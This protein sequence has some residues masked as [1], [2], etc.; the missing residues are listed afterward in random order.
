M[1]RDAL[2]SACKAYGL[3]IARDGTVKDMMFSY[4]QF[5]PEFV[6]NTKSGEPYDF[7]YSDIMKMR[8]EAENKALVLTLID[9][10]EVVLK[11]GA[12]YDDD[13][14]I[15]IN[16]TKM[17]REQS[18]LDDLFDV[19]FPDFKEKAY[20]DVL[21]EQGMIDPT[22]FGLDM[23]LDAT[24][25]FVPLVDEMYPFYYDLME[26][27]LRGM[28]L[29]G[30]CPPTTMRDIVLKKKLLENK[31][32]LFMEWVE[33][34]PWDGKPRLRRWFMDG[35]GATSNG[36]LTPEE[37]ELYIG[38]FTT[39]WF[40]GG[41]CR[42]REETKVE[43]VPVIIGGEGLGKG[44]FLRYTVGNNSEWFTDTSLP[45][46]GPGAE[47]KMLEAITGYV[48]VELSESTQF[49]TA[50]GSENLK[51]FVSKSRDKRR[52]AYARE[53]TISIRRFILAA[54]SNRNNVFMDVGGGNRRYFPVY[55]KPENCIRPFDPKNKKYRLEDAQQVWA[56]ALYI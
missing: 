52:K 50:K 43:I 29:T 34:K 53:S 40:I 47:E 1:D 55:C 27:R 3:K 10:S 25:K 15:I 42:M 45:L 2:I 38:N 24:R 4:G 11:G 30:R 17:P 5:T 6:V 33:S 56:E 18:E 12:E 9:D 16:T 37:E 22:L 41:L 54:T 8:Y 7:R 49:T 35:I 28:G 21:S 26:R 31:R 19:L 44:N 20:F 51:T 39:S 23:P 13:G 48:I 46:D 36:A 14:S 32:N